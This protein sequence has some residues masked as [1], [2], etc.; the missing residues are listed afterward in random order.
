MFRTRLVRVQKQNFNIFLLTHVFD[1]MCRG[2]DPMARFLILGVL[3]LAKVVRSKIQQAQHDPRHKQ[4]KKTILDAAWDGSL[5]AVR[6]LL[7]E[8]PA[9][10][11]FRDGGPAPQRSGL[12]LAQ[13]PSWH[14]GDT[15]LHRATS[16]SGRVAMCEL[17]LAA[18]ADPN[19]T[20][21][22]SREPRCLSGKLRDTPLHH[23]AENGR[24]E[25][26]QLLLAAKAAVDIKN[27][28]GHTALDL[29]ADIA[30]DSGLG[31]RE[32]GLSRLS[33]HCS[34]HAGVRVLADHSCAV[35]R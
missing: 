3:G 1:R 2:L 28:K 12:S 20:D 11:H 13:P 25:A 15:A 10:V 30:N 33:D 18:A 29:A 9:A 6:G 16:R 27:N 8:D 26:V 34:I 31:L 23:A 19:A 32:M 5:P 22:A 35:L 21:G 7:R 17:L 24:Q 14:R 4:R